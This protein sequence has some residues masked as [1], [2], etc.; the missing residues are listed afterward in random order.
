MFITVNVQVGNDRYS[1]N[2][3]QE[4]I[5]I[6]VPDALLELIKPQLSTM[7]GEVANKVLDLGI[8]KAKE[9]NTPAVESDEA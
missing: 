5:Q 8:A 9:K 4:Q 3:L 7:V 1:R 2:A 6:E